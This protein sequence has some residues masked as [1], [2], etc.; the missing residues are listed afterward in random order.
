[1]SSVV[2][3]KEVKKRIGQDQYLLFYVGGD[4]YAIEALTTSEIVEY[5]QTTKVPVMPS[6]V[7]GVTNIRGNI[8]P[9][10]DLLDRFGLGKSTINPK[11]SI[12]VVNYTLDTRTIQIGII[13]DEVYEV[14]DIH[15]EQVKDAPEFGAKIDKRFILRM[16]KYQG[17]YL[18]I[19]N[20]QTILDVN[21]LSKLVG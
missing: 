17:N 9:V 11:T 13:I 5:S 19:L 8:V 3:D 2:I 7:K 10:I 18:A 16:G 12:I 6:F 4:I 14:D 20:T 1:M 21:E 15:T